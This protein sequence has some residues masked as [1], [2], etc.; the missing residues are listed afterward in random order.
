L[1]ARS[2]RAKARITLSA[3]WGVRLTRNKNCFSPTGT[4]LT[5]VAAIAV[6]LRGAPSIRG[7][8]AEDAALRQGVDHTVAEADFDGSALDDE[9]LL[10]L[11]ALLEDNIAGVVS[12]HRARQRRPA[13]RN[14]WPYPP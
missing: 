14:R 12:A 4:S 11:V 6:A 1:V 3:K 5:P 13:G 10:G 2:R 7:H 9:Q 8:L